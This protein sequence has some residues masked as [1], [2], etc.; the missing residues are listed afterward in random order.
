MDM[1]RR[2]VGL[3]T[4][5]A[6]FAVLG[7]LVLNGPAAAA[8]G[9]PGSSYFAFINGG[10]EVPPTA[11]DVTGTASFR[12]RED[13]SSLEYTLAIYSINNLTMGHIHLGRPGANGPIVLSLIPK[14]TAMGQ[15]NVIVTGVAT[16]DMLEGPLKGQPLSALTSQMAAN[17]YVNF[18][19]T[20]FPGGEFRGN[21]ISSDANRLGTQPAVSTQVLIAP[22]G[23][24][25]Q[26]FGPANDIP[27]V[28]I[29]FVPNSAFVPATAAAPAVAPAATG[30][31]GAVINAGGVTGI[32]GAGVAGTQAPGRGPN[33][34]GDTGNPGVAPGQPGNQSATNTGGS[35]SS[36]AP[37]G[38]G[39]A[40]G[41]P[42]T[43]G[44]GSSN[45]N[46]G[47]GGAGT[48]GVGPNTGSTNIG[49]GQGFP[50][51]GPTGANTGS[52]TGNMG[53]GAG[54]IGNT[55]STAPRP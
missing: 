6:L 44:S 41:A 39:A 54:T 24:T 42:L 13:G 28:S 37:N 1:R 7:L 33:A 48:T 19:T 10:N 55:G 8:P 29:P 11:S 2:L 15:Q 51:G 3:V 12:L 34:T 5:I 4:G 14:Q 30:A 31:A 32:P 21:I 47:G 46:P 52:A 22:A 20:A 35:V 23:P 36:G 9:D 40:S 45:S 53:N 25:V 43:G 49:A 18:H 17:A 38:G 16:A 27:P 26:P 50:A